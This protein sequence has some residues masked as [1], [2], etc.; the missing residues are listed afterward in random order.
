MGGS[1]VELNELIVFT[2]PRVFFSW[3]YFE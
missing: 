3:L 1:G 2:V